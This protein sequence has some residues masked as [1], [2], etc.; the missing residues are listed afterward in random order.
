MA[1]GKS[2][3]SVFR[4]HPRDVSFF[5]P[6][7]FKD[8]LTLAETSRAVNRDPSWIRKLEREGKIP[9]AQRVQRGKISIRLWSPKQVEEIKNVLS[10]LRPGRPP[11]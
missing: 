7:K 2:G 9:K 10:T 3:T 1:R 8:Y 4:L 5:K 6:E 11:K